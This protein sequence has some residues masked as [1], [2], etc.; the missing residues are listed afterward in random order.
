MAAIKSISDQDIK[1]RVITQFT[2]GIHNIIVRNSVKLYVNTHGDHPDFISRDVY[3][4]EK[5][6]AKDTGKNSTLRTVLQ[7]IQPY[8]YVVKAE[9]RSGNQSKCQ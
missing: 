8:I 6:F 3:D 7:E 1:T 4:A 2:Q 9:T 5:Y